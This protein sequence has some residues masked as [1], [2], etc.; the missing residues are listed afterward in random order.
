[1]VMTTMT[2]L[3]IVHYTLKTDWLKQPR[4]FLIEPIWL[5]A[6]CLSNQTFFYIIISNPGWVKFRTNHIGDTNKQSILVNLTN[7]IV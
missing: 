2:M 5:V 1:M 3:T 7:Y 4:F 6:M